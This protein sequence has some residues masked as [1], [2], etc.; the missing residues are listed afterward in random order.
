[1]KGEGVY[2]VNYYIT[3]KSIN[4]WL[5]YEIYVKFNFIN[6]SVPLLGMNTLDMNRIAIKYNWFSI[7]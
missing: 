2:H 7:Q 6:I 4:G 5:K 3:N 1:M